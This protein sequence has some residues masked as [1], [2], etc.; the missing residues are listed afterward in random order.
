MIHSPQPP[1]D[2]PSIMKMLCQYV[3]CDIC[4]RSIINRYITHLRSLKSSTRQSFQLA[5]HLLASCEPLPLLPNSVSVPIRD[6]C[7]VH[8]AWCIM[9]QEPSLEIQRLLLRHSN[10]N[11]LRIR[12]LVDAHFIAGLHVTQVLRGDNDELAS[13][14]LLALGILR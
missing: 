14:L 3:E 8:G 9:V 13:P 6:V 12:H 2:L 7:M 1:A 5:G 10:V 11:P 4:D